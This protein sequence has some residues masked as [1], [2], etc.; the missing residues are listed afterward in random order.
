MNSVNT[1]Q[2]LIKR[3]FTAIPV[4]ML[5]ISGKA[6]S[7]E[8]ANNVNGTSGTVPVQSSQSSVAPV[9]VKPGDSAADIPEGFLRRPLKKG[10]SL[11]GL[12]KADSSCEIV[13]MKVNRIDQRHL[14]TGRNIL[15]PVDKEKSLNY[16]PVPKVLS[17]SRGEREIRIFLHRQYFGAYEKGELLF[18]GPVS[19]GKKGKNTPPGRFFVNYKQRFKRSLKYDD[20][21][22][23]FSINFN[24]GYFLHQQSMPGFPASHGCVRLLEVDAQ[25]LFNWIRLGDPVTLVIES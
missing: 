4:F 9:P 24:K 15:V 21:P 5:A 22:M 18:W 25:R 12:C 11:S 23:P 17:D 8:N 6:F 19:S 7:S 3:L 10:E 2:S 20:A 13:L 16:V 1:L 14:V